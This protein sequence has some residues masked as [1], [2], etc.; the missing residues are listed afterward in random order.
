[1][2]EI[3]SQAVIIS[4]GAPQVFILGPLLILIY[5][6]DIPKAVKCNLFLYANDSYLVSQ[7]KVVNEI[8]KQH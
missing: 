2:G 8:K 6:N 7:K 5:L 1:M 4:S 3:F